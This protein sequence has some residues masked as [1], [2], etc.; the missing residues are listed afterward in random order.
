M[1]EFKDE[2]L[3][4]GD[5]TLNSLKTYIL[6]EVKVQIKIEPPGVLKEEFRKMKELESIVSVLQDH[7]QYYQKQVNRLKHQNKELELYGRRLSIEVDVIP[8]VKNE[9]FNKVLD[10]FISLIY[11]L[12]VTLWKLSS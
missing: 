11:E 5:E 12:N 10:K 7:V 3:A 4:R 9:T 1:N 6:A 2:V 8:H